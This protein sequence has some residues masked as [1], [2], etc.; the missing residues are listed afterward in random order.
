MEVFNL[1]C[2]KLPRN[3]SVLDFGCGHGV[4]FTKELVKKSFEVNA[5]DISDTMIKAA[6]KNVP[7]EKYAKVSMTDIN[8]RNEFDVIYFVYS[9]RWLA[10]NNFEIAA[11]KAVNSLK[12]GGFF[13]LAFN[14][15]HP[16]WHNECENYAEIMGQ[17]IYSRPYT[18]DEV[19]E[20]FAELNMKI[21]K[22][23]RETV[24]SKAYGEEHT[25]LVFM[26]KLRSIPTA[27]QICEVDPK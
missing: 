5:I 13:F 7:E 1:F 27:F 3:A 2:N 19:K 8:V 20:V 16:A 14:E 24:S 12:Q 23:A 9:M 22:V 11:R 25:L 26:K 17:K 10:F 15:P 4:P 21:I 18:I 6:K